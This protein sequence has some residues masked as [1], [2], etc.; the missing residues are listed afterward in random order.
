MWIAFSVIAAIAMLLFWSGP[1]NAVW[2]GATFG[3]IG[4]LIVALCY[5]GDGFDW[6]TVGKGLVIGALVGLAIE[7]FAVM[8][9][10]LKKHHER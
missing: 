2:G 8:G 4:G 7:L 5:C 10:K 1:R 3:V 9:E 6:S